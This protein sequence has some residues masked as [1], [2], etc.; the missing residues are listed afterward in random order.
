MDSSKENCIF[1]KCWPK[2]GKANDPAAVLWTNSEHFYKKTKYA[3]LQGFVRCWL[4]TREPFEALLSD[5]WQLEGWGSIE[6]L[7][8]AKG[9]F[10][11]KLRTW[12]L[13]SQAL[14]R[15]GSVTWELEALWLEHW[16]LEDLLRL[17]ALLRTSEAEWATQCRPLWRPTDHQAAPANKRNIIV[18]YCIYIM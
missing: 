13:E 7:I 14:Q 9:L 18:Q 1:G 11:V 8:K 3:A 5:D 17:M 4:K 12:S 16:G 10:R 6:A 15:T 2:I